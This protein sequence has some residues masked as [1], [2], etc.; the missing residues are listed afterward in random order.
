MWNACFFFLN[1]N[2]IS[3]HFKN[4][5]RDF[6]AIH[7]CV[8]KEVNARSQARIISGPKVFYLILKIIEKTT[9][10]LIETPKTGRKLPDTLSV[11][12]IDTY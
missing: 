5:R 6:A 9:L 4:W 12:E 3:F 11:I 1:E 10:E 7:L 8:A 2:E